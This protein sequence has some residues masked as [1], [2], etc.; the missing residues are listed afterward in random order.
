MYIPPPGDGRIPR[1]QASKYT[2]FQ[3]SNVKIPGTDERENGNL[4]KKIRP[5]KRIG[6]L[7][8]GG[9]EPAT[10][11][12]RRVAFKPVFFSPISVGPL[13]AIDCPI[14][15]H[16][17]TSLADALLRRRSPTLTRALQCARS[18]LVRSGS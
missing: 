10:H 4:L 13:R 5:G 12:V 1:R 14:V 16:V 17:G 15:R 18:R 2:T 8:S 11:W 3:E 6:A 7:V 9:F